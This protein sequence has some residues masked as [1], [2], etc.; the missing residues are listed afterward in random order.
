MVDKKYSYRLK[1]PLRGLP[2]RW[3]SKIL[4]VRGHF[5][6]SCSHGKRKRKN[7]IHSN[8]MACLAGKAG[9]LQCHCPLRWCETVGWH[10]S[11]VEHFLDTVKT[12]DF[13][14]WE[15]KSCHT[16]RKMHFSTF[17]LLLFWSTSHFQRSCCRTMICSWFFLK[18]KQVF[19]DTTSFLYFWKRK[20][21][22]NWN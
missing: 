12:G 14:H 11:A 6:D 17:S 7:C 22:C 15:V 4:L 1:L 18:G 19:L 10:D 2:Q 3:L 9:A 13:C 21:K 5:A 20:R 8:G 16:L